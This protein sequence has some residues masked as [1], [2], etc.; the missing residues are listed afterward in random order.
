M[1]RSKDD[2]VGV[3]EA[4]LIDMG[5]AEETA[6]ALVVAPVEDPQTSPLGRETPW[7]T[8]AGSGLGVLWMAATG[9]FLFGYLGE[10]GL[11]NAP[12]YL[13]AGYLAFA[14]APALVL[15]IAGALGDALRRSGRES[16]RLAAAVERLMRPGPEAE[17]VALGVAASVRGE[18]DRLDQ[19][20]S[21]ILARLKEAERLTAERAQALH[22]AGETTR[23]GATA[24]AST[25]ERERDALQALAQRVVEEA[26]KASA[27]VQLTLGQQV[28]AISALRGDLEAAAAKA[29]D[30]IAQ[31]AVAQREAGEQSARQIGA[32]MSGLVGQLQ[33]MMDRE[34]GALSAMQSGLV[35]DAE[36]AARTVVTALDAERARIEALGAALAQQSQQGL[37]ALRGQAEESVRTADALTEKAEVARSLMDGAANTVAAAAER[38]AEAGRLAAS[39]IEAALTQLSAMGREAETAAQ[40]LEAA[41]ARGRTAMDDAAALLADA[42]G[43]SGDASQ[44]TLAAAQALAVS[45]REAAATSDSAHAAMTEQGRALLDEL[46]RSVSASMEDLS[47]LSST[48]LS[49]ADVASARLSEHRAALTEESDRTLQALSSQA[50]AVAETARAAAAE[51][52]AAAESQADAMTK[53]IEAAGEAAFEAARRADQVLEARLLDAEKL[54]GTVNASV[55]SAGARALERFQEAAA[56]MQAHANEVEQAFA[57]IQGRMNKFPA[58]AEA[59]SQA[60]ER[61]LEA[62]LQRLNAAGKAAFE[63]AAGLDRAFQGRLRESYAAMGELVARLGGLAGVAPA[64][65]SPPPSL[66]AAPVQPEQPQ[67]AA[68]PPGRRLGLAPVAEEPAAP[69]PKEPD[70]D[71]I[72]AEAGGVAPARGTGE[73]WSWKDLLSSIEPEPAP[74]AAKA[75][76][77]PHAALH[78]AILGLGVTPEL[79]LPEPA[80][81]RAFARGELSLAGRRNVVRETAGE[82]VGLIAERAR[83]DLKLRAA[84]ERFV[85]TVGDAAQAGKGGD[86][87]RRLYLLLDAALA[88]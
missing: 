26:N 7:L 83:A 53:R 36:A 37:A 71:A 49:S 77:G 76:R 54:A 35:A 55:S 18:L 63:E 75:R 86:A 42:V 61:A 80:M 23:F 15:G 66:P 5:S 1:S 60:I 39:R 27:G 59:Q 82:A 4:E 64:V 47:R 62:S 29:A 31:S 22:V 45:A 13:L 10:T 57:A 3:H 72:F 58:I 67:P 6:G 74:A 65:A 73:P 88:A 50:A 51:A 24:L 68:K 81:Q 78:D 43:K 87:D 56:A 69:P 41:S 52:R 70:F 84:I 85:A 30:A 38:A 2:A 28:E 32:D 11:S 19:T 79:V 48:V 12:P 17:R 40:V 9:A 20:I 14:A 25:L 46:R 16:R 8:L 21:T 44:S 33:A 34:R